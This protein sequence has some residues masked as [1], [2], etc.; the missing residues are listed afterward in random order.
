LAVQLPSLIVQPTTASLQ[1]ATPIKESDTHHHFFIPATLHIGQD[2][3]SYPQNPASAEHRNITFFKYLCN[4]F[5][6]NPKQ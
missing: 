4:R 2:F 5:L 6:Y 3:T 1:S